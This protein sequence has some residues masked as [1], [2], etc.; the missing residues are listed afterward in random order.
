MQVPAGEKAIQTTDAPLVHTPLPE[1]ESKSTEKKLETDL[2]KPQE[3]KIADTF[4]G[5]FM[6]LFTFFGI[7]FVGNSTLSLVFTYIFNSRPETK[8]LREDIIGGISKVAGVAGDESS[9]LGKG[10][11][12]A[13]EMC[14]MFIAG[15]TVTAIMQPLIHYGDRLA[16][17]INKLLGKDADV[18]P[19]ELKPL[20]DPKTVEEKIAQEVGKKIQKH[21]PFDLWVSR[22]ISM[23]TVL[24]GDV[25]VTQAGLKAEKHNLPSL[26]TV[27][28][29]IGRFLYSIMPKDLSAGLNRWFANHDASLEDI[30]KNSPDHYD[31]LVKNNTQYSV[32]KGNNPEEQCTSEQGRLVVKELGWTGFLAVTM[33]K[34]THSLKEWRKDRQLEKAV[35]EL[36][37]QGLIQD[38]YEVKRVED[39][40]EVKAPVGKENRPWQD[41][42][43]VN[44]NTPQPSQS[45]RKARQ[46]SKAMVQGLSLQ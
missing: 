17:G 5:K 11:R 39:K 7:G 21:S 3:Q 46:E 4:G 14:F 29:G 45:Y 1:P 43:K 28:W 27:S 37:R 34:L 20:K 18:L 36:S 9:S 12:S 19:D 41:T 44:K 25:V 16:H 26:D 6:K 42:V 30:Q 31:R 40:I 32:Y 2:N 35:K 24:I 23:A 15:I 33:E 10:I 8:K 38:G 13:V 22:A